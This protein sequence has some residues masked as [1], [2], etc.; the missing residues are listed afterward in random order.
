MT[1]HYALLGLLSWQPFSGYDL[2]KIILDNDMFYWSGNNNQI[3]TSLIQLHKNGL[4]TQ[5]VHYQ[6]NLPAKKVYSITESGRIQL[7]E[8]V[9]SNIELPEYRNTFLIQLAWAD[10]LST[11]E[12]D[13]L[14]EKYENEIR[15]Q[16]DMQQEKAR[17][18]AVMP[19]R[20]LRERYLWEKVV[21]H[22]AQNYQN[23]LKWVRQVRKGLK[24]I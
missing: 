10:L 20:T 7:R 8:W 9:I 19:K 11:S 23:E 21:D 17:R 22:Q 1:I 5:E 2:K 4:V 3:Y 13:A 15:V 18:P 12:I 16:V 24:E 6:E 14:L